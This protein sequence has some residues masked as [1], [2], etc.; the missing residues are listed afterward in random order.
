MLK[1]CENYR[2]RSQN[3]Q[4]RCQKYRKRCYNCRNQCQNYRNDV[5][6]AGNDDKEKKKTM[7][8]LLIV[9]VQIGFLLQMFRKGGFSGILILEMSTVKNCQGKSGKIFFRTGNDVIMRRHLCVFV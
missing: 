7:S 8:K 3:D 1:L 2:K 5:Y 9:E 6:T 4:N